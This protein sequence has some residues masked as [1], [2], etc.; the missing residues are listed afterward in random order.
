MMMGEMKMK[1]EA[2]M[3]K[4]ITRTKHLVGQGILNGEVSLYC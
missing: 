4:G 3:K 2:N 1:N